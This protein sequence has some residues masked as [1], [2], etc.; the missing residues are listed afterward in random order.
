MQTPALRTHF[1]D[2]DFR[3]VPLGPPDKTCCVCQRLLPAKHPDGAR[4]TVRLS[5]DD[6][7]VIHPDDAT[8]DNST[9]AFVGP[10]CAGRIP[11]EFFI[12]IS[13]PSP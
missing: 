8:D 9:V 7:S 12:Y 4:R 3:R 2:P 13:E 1:I 5:K 11:P 6:S 10:D